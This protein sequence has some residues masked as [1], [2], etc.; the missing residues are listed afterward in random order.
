MSNANEPNQPPENLSET[1]ASLQR[2][3]ADEEGISTEIVEALKELP[4][5]QRKIV[6]SL[7]LSLER[8]SASNTSPLAKRITSEHITQTLDNL[9]KE[10]ERN[11]K[12][13]QAGET[14]KRLGMAAILALVLMVLGYAGLTKDKD[15][16]EK[17]IIAG[18]AGIGGFGAGV[19]ASKKEP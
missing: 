4:P 12:K 2:E 18:I 10:N 8:T 5:S 19:A 6:T 16:A 1:E 14:T 9:E 3:L 17:V 13:S 11:F 15:L 7:F